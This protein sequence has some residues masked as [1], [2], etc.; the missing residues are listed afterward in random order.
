MNHLRPHNRGKR[1][2]RADETHT[3]PHLL[4]QTMNKYLHTL[5]NKSET[6]NSNHIHTKH[7]ETQ[8]NTEKVKNIKH[9]EKIENRKT[10]EK[11][12][13]NGSLAIIN[14]INKP[15]LSSYIPS[16]KTTHTQISITR[17]TIPT[18]K[19]SRPHTP[20]SLLKPSQVCPEPP[21]KPRPDHNIT[22][23]DLPVRVLNFSMEEVIT[24][25]HLTS[26]LTFSPNLS[27]SRQSKITD[28]FAIFTNT[29]SPSTSTP[30]TTTEMPKCT[31]CPKG[32]EKYNNKRAAIRSKLLHY[33]PP[34]QTQQKIT[35]FTSPI[36]AHELTEAWGHSLEV[37][38]PTTTFRI[39]LQN[40]NGLSISMLNYSLQQDLQTCHKYGAAVLYMPE[41]NTNW[42][43]P[44]Q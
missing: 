43:L 3:S 13:Q 20:S 6:D 11:V 2:R 8:E 30:V 21:T 24:P 12:T 36:P 42:A 33:H 31:G 23:N 17:Y 5:T 10:P 7:L 4:Q 28:Y 32:K 14:T 19:H 26:A 16:K 1:G 9:T 41:T 34:Q 27:T 29:R 35:S 25:D 15:T 40:P 37:I 22:R 18:L 38:D 44:H 39:F